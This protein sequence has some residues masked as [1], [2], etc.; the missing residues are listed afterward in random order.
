MNTRP[1]PLDGIRVLDLTRNLPGPMATLQ[2]A[3]FGADVLRIDD[4]RIG[5]QQPP[6]HED[7]AR[8]MFTALNRNK[9][10]IALDL[11]QAAGREEFLRLAAAADVI[12]EGFRP[13]VM[14]RLGLGYEAVRAVNP[15]IVYCSISGY[16]Q[17]G[18]LRGQA[19]HDINY[20]AAAGIL[21]QIGAPGCAP[22][23]PNIQIADA[24]GGSLTAVMGILTALID[25]KTRGTGRYVD[26]SMTDSVLT[27]SVVALSSMLAN[28]APA[29][30]GDDILSGAL[31]C[32]TTYRTADGRYLA[33]GA[34]EP[35]FWEALCD[36][37]ERP[38]LKSK[39]LACGEEARH[40]KHEL[41]NIFAAGPSDYWIEK[42]RSADCCVNLVLRL[43]EA[44]RSPHAIARGLVIES[45]GMVEFAPPLKMSDFDPFDH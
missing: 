15:R 8:R 34:L 38:D 6:F 9:R 35:K 27:H 29:E 41:A 39:R 22:A 11:K 26:V 24:F 23:I 30:R 43:D 21:D 33:V 10:A 13:G 18:P 19:G 17:T 32:Y 31:A 28:G 42:L 25:A 14:D 45:G 12:V 20:L 36:A 1:K 7:A 3:N 37:L 16:G 40:V 2:L 44:I 4:A 5:P